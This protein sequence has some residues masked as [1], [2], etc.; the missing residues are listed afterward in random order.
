[1]SQLSMLVPGLQIGQAAESTLIYIRGVGSDNA[2]ELGDPA[3]G[4][5][6]DG[7]YL[8]RFRGLSTA[9]LDVQRVEV[10]SGPQGTV[11]GRN[12][13]GGAVNIIS[14]PAVFG[15]YQGNA[16]LTYGSYRQRAYQA[17]LNLPF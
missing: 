4:V 10:S 1:I 16:E 13:V 5:H 6:V 3:V 7:V 2:T 14:K 12:A 15:E 9:W 11:R 17:M 8:P